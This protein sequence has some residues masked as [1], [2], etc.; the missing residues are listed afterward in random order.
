MQVSNDQIRQQVTEL[1]NS[2]GRSPFLFLGSGFSRR[3]LG[4]ESWDGLLRSLGAFYSDDPFLLESYRLRLQEQGLNSGNPAVA[5][6]MEKD[7]KKAVLGNP[8]LSQF[9]D[10]HADSLRQGESLLKIVAALHLSAF[11]KTLMNGEIAKLRRAGERRIAGVIQ[12]I[13][14]T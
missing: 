14:T 3:Y 7:L 8:S 11:K 10:E 6:L 5:S 12:R 9:R 4:T 13:M 1:I 2:A